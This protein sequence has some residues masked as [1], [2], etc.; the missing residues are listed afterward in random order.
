VC[1]SRILLAIESSSARASKL[2][3][4][5]IAENV[6]QPADL[7]RFGNDRQGFVE[8]FLIIAVAWPKHHAMGAKADWHA[9]AV[10]RDMS[11]CQ[12]RHFI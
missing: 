6:V 10:N 2:A 4:A 5:T 11:N 3:T 9:I 1:S 8:Y 7:G 12:D